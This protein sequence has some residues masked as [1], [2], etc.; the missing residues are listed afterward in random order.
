MCFT[1]LLL[2]NNLGR[3]WLIADASG[4]GALVPVPGLSVALDLGLLTN[5]VNFY[6]SQ[7]NSSELRKLTPEI[8]EKVRKFCLT[9]AVQ[10]GQLVAAYTASSEVEKLTKYIPILESLINGSISF[11]STYYFL[12]GC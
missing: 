7:E 3:I 4:A 10:I 5:E 1:A 6:K 9:G 11:T 2:C 12:R 8:Q